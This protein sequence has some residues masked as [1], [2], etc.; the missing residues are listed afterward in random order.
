[1]AKRPTQRYTPAVTST[2]G[3]ADFIGFVGAW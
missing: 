2:I 3:G 1:M